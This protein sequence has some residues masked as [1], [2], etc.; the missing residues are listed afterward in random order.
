MVNRKTRA[1]ATNKAKR[2]LRSQTDPEE[3]R[4][5]E[6]TDEDEEKGKGARPKTHS[7]QP[8]TSEFL[9]LM[10]SVMEIHRKT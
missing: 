8:A 6:T 1:K 2:S 4:A 5:M 10:R 3:E 9:G 7:A